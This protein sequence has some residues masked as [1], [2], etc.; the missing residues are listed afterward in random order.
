[1]AKLRAWTPAVAGAAVVAVGC[2][3]V[4]AAISTLTDDGDG[5]VPAPTTATLP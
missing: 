2:L 1:M 3:Y 4:F 5:L